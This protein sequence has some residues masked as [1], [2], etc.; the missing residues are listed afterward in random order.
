MCV[1]VVREDL[2]FLVHQ[3]LEAARV[4]SELH[5]AVLALKVARVRL[6]RVDDALKVPLVA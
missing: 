6:D 1:C 5:D 3:R 4:A 2:H